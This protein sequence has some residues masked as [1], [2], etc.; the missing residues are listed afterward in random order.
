MS[1]DVAVLLIVLSLVLGGVALLLTPALALAQF[2][3]DVFFAQPSIAVP[4]GGT[5][6][7]GAAVSSE[8]TE[9]WSASISYPDS[10]VAEVAD[11]VRRCLDMAGRSG[12]ILSSSNTI[13]RGVKP[14]NYRAM[15]DALREFGC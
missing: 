9:G 14:E 8:G 13:H 6:V 15:L 5:V 10:S 2:P 7:S 3:G 12:Y 11:E 1:P 4:E